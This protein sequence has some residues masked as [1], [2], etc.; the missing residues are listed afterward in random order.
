MK[1][2]SKTAMMLAGRELMRVAKR[3]KKARGSPPPPE[4]TSGAE[5]EPRTNAEVDSC[6]KDCEA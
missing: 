4:E 3:I 2:P 1:Q 6:S 5:D